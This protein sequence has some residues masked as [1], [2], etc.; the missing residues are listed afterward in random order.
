MTS[1]VVEKTLVSK[2]CVKG[3]WLFEA[4]LMSA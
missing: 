3:M 1:I 2:P 4:V